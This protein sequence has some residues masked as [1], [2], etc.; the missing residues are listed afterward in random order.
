MSPSGMYFSYRLMEGPSRTRNAIRLLQQLEF[1]PE[2]TAAAQ[3]LAAGFDR[4][5]KWR[6]E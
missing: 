5:G 6:K 3:S 4:T 1:P 2:V